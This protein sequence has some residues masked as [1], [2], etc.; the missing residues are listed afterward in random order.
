VTRSG[1]ACARHGAETAI[2]RATYAAPDV[3]WVVDQVA[4][5]E[6]AFAFRIA[7]I[8]ERGGGGTS[9]FEVR[10]AAF[11][12]PAAK[13]HSCSSFG[14][15]GV[16]GRLAVF[17]DC[18]ISATTST[19]SPTARSWPPRGDRSAAGS[20]SPSAR[21][22]RQ[23]VARSP[24]PPPAGS[25]CAPCVVLLV[26]A[27]RSARRGTLSVID[28]RGRIRR[29]SSRANANHTQSLDVDGRRLAWIERTTA[30]PRLRVTP[31]G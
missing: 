14:G 20:P 11:G 28:P 17:D 2:A 30:G 27:D 10:G 5:S 15:L 4:A 8:V 1:A 21:L 6:E 26:R 12:E 31:I 22:E 9:H 16:V 19:S 25:S 7:Q 23:V 29:V 3:F 24:L 18:D 13:L